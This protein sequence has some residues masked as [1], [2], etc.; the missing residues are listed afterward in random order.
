MAIQKVIRVMC[1][2][3][4]GLAQEADENSISGMR[5]GVPERSG[6]VNISTSLGGVEAIELK[7]LCAKCEKRVVTLLKMV[8]LDKDDTKPPPEGI[9]VPEEEKTSA[10]KLADAGRRPGDVVVTQET[11]APIEHD[12]TPPVGDTGDPKAHKAGSNKSSRNKS[13]EGSHG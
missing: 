2:R 7:D 5:A 11:G 6:V 13:Q 12:K 9:P 4:G 8:R 3:C 1:D 10:E